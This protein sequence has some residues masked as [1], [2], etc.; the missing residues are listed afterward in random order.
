MAFFVIATVE[1]ACLA[2][3]ALAAAVIYHLLAYS[4]Q[5]FTS[6]Y[7]VV[8]LLLGFTEV[9]IAAW[10]GQHAHL[11]N[12]R[13]ISFASSGLV[14]LIATFLLLTSL[15]FL[16]K[17]SDFYSRGTLILQFGSCWVVILAVRLGTYSRFQAAVADGLIRA[18]RIILIG[19]RDDC[20]EY[21]RQLKKP[22][23]AKISFC[24]LLPTAK[25]DKSDALR[26][27]EQCR[28]FQADSIIMLVDKEGQDES[29]GTLASYLREIP[30]DVYAVPVRGAKFWATARPAEVGGVAV[31][32]LSHRPLS[33]FELIIK[34][35]FDIV[36]AT[37]GLIVLSPL[38]LLAA[39]AVF[40]DSKGPIFFGQIR[41][42]YNN[43]PI[44][45]LK[46]RTMYVTQ[47]SEF[48]QASRDD[49][50]ITQVGRV[51]RITG[52]DELPQLWNILRG[53]MSVVGPRPHAIPHNELF[54]PRIES[55]SR[56]HTV[57]P[58][59]TGWAQV[60]G[61][62]GETDTLEK[63]QKR[64]EHD[65]YYIDNWSLLFD[66]QIIVMTLFS[67]KTYINAH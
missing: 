61:L 22:G 4:P 45:V 9:C 51:L 5:D 14:A 37:G 50:R 63:M 54:I 47:D 34:R 36:A 39:I 11:Q 17:L 62:R 7:A 23:G 21:A 30:A 64:I 57:K 3:A 27:I 8:S 58:G 66:F 53:D 38:L 32:A 13:R 49:S 46:F 6:R 10:L 26:I 19:S 33:M 31:F 55:F 18:Q 59:L 2:I 1:F 24:P 25:P 41:H 43:Y 15:L 48:R 42:G 44:R 16:F 60:N 40:M 67:A 29:F 35:A 28:L 12:L 20:A 65:L 52:I 56:R